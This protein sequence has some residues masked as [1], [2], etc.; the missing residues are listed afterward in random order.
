MHRQDGTS[1]SDQDYYTSP[2]GTTWQDWHTYVIEWRAGVSCEFFLDGVS[3]G[4][5]TARVPATP[6]HLVM[7]FETQLTAEKPAASTSG[8]VEIDYLTVSVPS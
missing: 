4:K 8:Y 2:A 5:S 6:M 7:Q 3:I 1:G